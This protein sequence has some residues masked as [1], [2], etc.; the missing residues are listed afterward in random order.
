MGHGGNMG[1]EDF[2]HF[3]DNDCVKYSDNKG[4]HIRMIRFL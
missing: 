3:C 4:D 2:T 1:Y